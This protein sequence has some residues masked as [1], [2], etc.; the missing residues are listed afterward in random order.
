MTRIILGPKYAAETRTETFDFT[1]RLALAETL[2]TA[3]VTATVYSGTDASP[4][5][6]VSGS[7]GISGAKVTQLI[8]AG[9]VGV[10]YML[11]CSVTTST[12][13]TLVL[14]GYMT[15]VPTSV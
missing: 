8:T 9:T 3:S 10:T 13:Q 5:A 6:L 4:S 11:S 12:G 15:V 7:A 14:K 1:S 2:S